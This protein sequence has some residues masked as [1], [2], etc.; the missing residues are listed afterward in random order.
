MVILADTSI[1]IDYSRRTD[2]SVVALARQGLICSHPF[3]S[4]ELAAGSLHLQHRMLL[5]IRNLPQLPVVSEDHF[6]AFIEVN[7]VNGKGLGFVDIHLLAAISQAKGAVL[8]T[9]DRRM[10]EQAEHLGV[11]Y[12]P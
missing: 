11:A 5:M 1:W 7:A 3:V 9:K 8:W 10:L 4:G 2:G 12:R 6:Y